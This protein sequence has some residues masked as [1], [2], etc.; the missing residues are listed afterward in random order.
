MPPAT[1]TLV[2]TPAPLTVSERAL[3]AAELATPAPSPT[4]SP[5]LEPLPAPA[6]ETP[7]PQVAE[8]VPAGS[9]EA[10]ICSYDWTPYTC[11]QVVNVAACESGRDLNGY[12]DGNW[13]IGGGHNFGV[14]QL[15]DVHLGSWPD[16]FDD[17][18]GDGVPNWASV[19]WN[20]AHAY[21]L[22]VSAG[23]SLIDWSCRWAAY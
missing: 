21:S 1:P 22:F 13:A 15:N 14:L 12:L 2:E 17:P 7:A 10:V 18:D 23:R 11:G 20:I 8:P 5:T 19:D 4:P 9:I 3:F 16:F 6:A